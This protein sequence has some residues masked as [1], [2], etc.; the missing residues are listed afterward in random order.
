MSHGPVSRPLLS[1]RLL[2]ATLSFVALLWIVHLLRLAL[3]FLGL[4]P[5]HTS[6]LIFGIHPGSGVTGL[7]TIF[8]APLIHAGWQHLSR[9]SVSLLILG[10]L[11]GLQGRGQLWKVSIISALTSGLGIWLIAP[12]HTVHGGASGIVF[13]HLGAL[14]LMG[15]FQRRPLT[16]L[17]SIACLVLFGEMVV[18][19]FPGAPGVSWQ[20]H[21]FGFLGGVLAARLTARSPA[22]KT[23]R[24]FNRSAVGKDKQPLMA[25]GQGILAL[26]RRR[27][28]RGFTVNDAVLE[29]EHSPETIRLELEKLM[30]EDCLYVTNDLKGRIIYREP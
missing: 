29:L 1:G 14:L 3:A 19:M 25:L 23:E 5:S 18:G 26:A 6:W 10:S 17:L 11:V 13:G 24:L 21:L 28:V 8:T 12:Y 27:G 4:L 22:P 7:W 30:K 9:N 20:G 2:P 15:W 16:I